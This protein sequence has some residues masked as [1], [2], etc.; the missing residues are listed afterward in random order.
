MNELKRSLDFPQLNSTERKKLRIEPVAD[1]RHNS[2]ALRFEQLPNELLMEIFE[3]LDAYDIHRGF[4]NLN[5]RFQNLLVSSSF[6]LKTVFAEQSLSTMEYR[7]RHVIAPNTRRLLS[8]HLYG[9]RTIRGFFDQYNFDSSL[10]RLE[11]VL[12]KD[13]SSHKLLMILSYIHSLPRLFSLTIQ[14]NNDSEDAVSDIF[15]LVF[16]LP[17]LK[18]FQISIMHYYDG[19]DSDNIVMPMLINE[20]FSTIER[21]NLDL[22]LNANGLASILQHTPQLQYLKCETLVESEVI[23]TSPILNLPN[24]IH[25]S[26]STIDVSF[27]A[28]KKFLIPVCRPLQ[29]LALTISGYDV[30]YRNG[31]RWQ[32]FIENH[33]PHLRTFH[34]KYSEYQT[35]DIL[36]DQE[37]IHQFTSTFWRERQWFFSFEE[38]DY[39]Y[40]N[41]QYVF[42]V[43]PFRKTWYNPSKSELINNQ[44]HPISLTVTQNALYTF[45]TSYVECMETCFRTVPFTH[46]NIK[47]DKIPSGLFIDLIHSLPNLTSLEVAAVP[48][49]KADSLSFEESETALLIAIKNK[50]MKIK[51]G[52]NGAVKDI[53]FILN[54]CPRVKYLEAQ[55]TTDEELEHLLGVIS[56][57]N[58]ICTVHL[59]CL[60]VCASTAKE[61]IINKIHGIIEFERLFNSEDAFRDYVIQSTDERI[62]LKWNL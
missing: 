17:V 62:L 45:G 35:E 56:M 53:D 23:D 59:D 38:K 41:E 34:L 5:L 50:I 19:D 32:R 16:R 31:N 25:V 61:K 4:S 6:P 44:T 7:C 2:V 36:F 28:L 57:N 18:H 48:N 29:Y 58:R 55:Y 8:I 30:N 24:L 11:S 20:K 49:I 39:P 3:Y 27:D 26:L 12:L 13:V 10:T 42:S 22:I 15:R 52:K 43:H 14:F 1:T 60:A 54:L 33:M 46:L 47:C 51:I 40:S 9:K 37:E 21:L